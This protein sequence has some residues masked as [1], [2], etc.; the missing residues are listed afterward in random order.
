MSDG[1]LMEVLGRSGGHETLLDEVGW[2][3][4]YMLLYKNLNLCHDRLRL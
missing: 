4:Q 1:C 3:R 2:I